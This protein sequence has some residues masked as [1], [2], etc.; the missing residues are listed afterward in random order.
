[1]K[2][3]EAAFWEPA[4]SGEMSSQKLQLVIAE[5]LAQSNPLENT[6]HEPKN[7]ISLH[8]YYFISAGHVRQEVL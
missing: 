1:L 5:R 2:T 8:K 3:T 6:L 7:Y 4:A